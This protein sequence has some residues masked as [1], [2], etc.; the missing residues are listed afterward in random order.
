M[1][2]LGVILGLLNAILLFVI[3]AY[4]KKPVIQLLE[5]AIRELDYKQNGYIVT[6]EENKFEEILRLQKEEKNQSYEN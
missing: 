3:L 5:R 6:D 1:L 4:F 2:L